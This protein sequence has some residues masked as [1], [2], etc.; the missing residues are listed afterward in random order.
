[1]KVLIIIPAFNEEGNIKSVIKSIREASLDFDIIVINDCSTDDTEAVAKSLNVDVISLPLNLGI[2]GAVQT[3]FQYAYNNNYDIAI[4][5]DGDGQH[6]PKYIKKLIDPLNKGD[7]DVV[8]GSR[9]IDKK[10]FQSKFFRRLGIRFFQL[11]INILVRCNI[12]DSTSGFRAYNAKAIELLKDQYPIDF[13]EPEAI[14]ILKKRKF[15]I[16]EV[17]VEMEN[18]AAGISSISTLKSIYYMV[19][20][21]ISIIVEFLRSNNG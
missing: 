3:G 10:G 16:I 19:K 1:M 13:P 12:T 6:N 21:T 9:F 11:L 7:V 17:P 14:I 5:I 20:V 8:N 4:Q 18:R 15:R 2:G